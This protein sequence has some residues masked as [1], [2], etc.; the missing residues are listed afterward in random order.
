[1]TDISNI[2]RLFAPKLYDSGSFKLK[3]HYF[4]ENHDKQK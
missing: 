3:K 4:N 1:M 2:I